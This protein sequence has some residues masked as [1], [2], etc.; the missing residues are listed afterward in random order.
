M[1]AVTRDPRAKRSAR[2]LHALDGI[3]GFAM[4]YVVVVHALISY[5]ATDIGWA[6]RDDERHLAADLLVWIAHAFL[7]PVFFVVAGYLSRAVVVSRGVAAFARRRATRVLVPLLVFVVPNSMAMNAMWDWGKSLYDPGQPHA[8][9]PTLDTSPLPITLSHLWYLYY[10][11]LASAAAALVI[12]ALGAASRAISAPRRAQ[13][14]TAAS[15]PWAPAVVA[16][17][18]AAVFAWAGKIQLDTPLGLAI[19]WPILLFHLIFYLYG[20]ILH[21]R[22]D[23][24]SR[25]GARERSHGLL[26]VAAFALVIPGLAASA[27]PEAGRPSTVSILASALFACY[28]TSAFI[29]VFVARLRRPRP[30]IRLLADASYWCY[31]LHLPIV[32][33]LQIGFW[34][35]PL[36]G[37]IEFVAITAATMTVCLLTYVW[38]VRGRYLARFMG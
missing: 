28:A 13:L 10:L 18:V 20:W 33:L 32:V 38:L 27:D 17:G 36:P 37:P 2:R 30:S 5:M 15:A 25:L 21:M 12:G 26:A 9:L 3:R 4:L 8:Q 31:V 29:A 24:L 34:W 6:I 22:P 1:S 35:L 16:I 11:L 19:D 23:S 7:M 14:I